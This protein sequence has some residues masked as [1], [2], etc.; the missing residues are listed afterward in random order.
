[1]TSFFKEV[2]DSRLPSSQWLAC[3]AFA[4]SAAVTRSLQ[5]DFKAFD[6][7]LPK[8]AIQ[9]V[10][11]SY[12]QTNE[13]V[14]AAVAYAQTNEFKMEYRKVLRLTVVDYLQLAGDNAGEFLDA[15]NLYK[16]V[17]AFFG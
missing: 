6:D 2:R 7:L 11:A 17:Q 4:A 13:D 15:N 5:S 14:Q 12:V 3:I 8:E 1:M 9:R 10:V 16:L